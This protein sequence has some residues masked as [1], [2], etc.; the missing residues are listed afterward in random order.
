[1][2]AEQK[3]KAKWGG[4]AA[5]LIMVAVFAYTLGWAGI[6]ADKRGETKVTANDQAQ[7]Q[8]VNSGQWTAQDSRSLEQDVNK[9]IADFQRQQA[10]ENFERQQQKLAADDPFKMP[11]GLKPGNWTKTIDGVKVRVEAPKDVTVWTDEYGNFQF[12][13]ASSL[14]TISWVWKDGSG[15]IIDEETHKTSRM[16]EQDGVIFDSITLDIEGAKIF[17]MRVQ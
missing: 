8:K 2:T 1:M 6:F 11:S 15:K 16:R 9:N 7:S 14:S 13:P 4:L 10:L 12:A 5:V 17:E 3:K